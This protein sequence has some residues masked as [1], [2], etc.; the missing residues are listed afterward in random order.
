MAHSGPR[1]V[2]DWARPGSWSGR[3]AAD[4]ARQSAALDLATPKAAAEHK[5][6]PG[7]MPTPQGVRAAMMANTGAHMLDARGLAGALGKDN[8]FAAR[9]EQ[10]MMENKSMQRAFTHQMMSQVEHKGWG[11]LHGAS[12]GAAKNLVNQK[13]SDFKAAKKK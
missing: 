1:S 9:I 2:D 8:K 4:S 3:A 6:L 10:K 7:G 13:L 11:A 5:A 12:Q